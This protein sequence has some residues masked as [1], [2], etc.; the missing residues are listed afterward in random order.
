MVLNLAI[1]EQYFLGNYQFPSCLSTIELTCLPQQEAALF[2]FKSSRAADMSYISAR[3]TNPLIVVSL[4]SAST[5]VPDFYVDNI[6]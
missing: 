5:F 3:A 2:P 1:S 6:F 4:V